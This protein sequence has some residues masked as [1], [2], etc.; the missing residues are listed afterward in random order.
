MVRWVLNWFDDV[1]VGHWADE[2]VG[3]AVSSGVMGGVADGR[4]DWEGVVPRWQIVTSLFRASQLVGGSVGEEEM[5]GSDSF[6][7]VPVGHG[8]GSGD[9]MGGGEWDYSGGGW[10]TVWSGW[11]GDAGADCDVFTSVD[12]FGGWSGGCWGVGVG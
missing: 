3:W 1:P 12:W 6:V 7:D 2:E 10:W 5:V 8:G 9:R 4:F 11:V